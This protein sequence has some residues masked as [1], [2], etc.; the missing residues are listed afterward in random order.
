MKTFKGFENNLQESGGGDA[1]SLAAWEVDPIQVNVPGDWNDKKLE[2]GLKKPLIRNE[3]DLETNLKAGI[4][5]L[6][7]KGFGKSGQSPSN[8]PDAT[9]DGW[10]TALQR[11]N[12]RTDI[13]KNGKTYSQNY[14]DTIV[15]RSQTTE[16]HIAIELP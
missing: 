10:A 15:E 5:L 14:A 13:R 2:L 16:R 9:F 8:R 12:G 1:R 6:C 3:G 11:Y 4:A 7:R